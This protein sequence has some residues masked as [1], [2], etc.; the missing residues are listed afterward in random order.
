LVRRD[1][2]FCLDSFVL[3][4]QRVNLCEVFFDYI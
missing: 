1:A 2:H 3:F 4:V